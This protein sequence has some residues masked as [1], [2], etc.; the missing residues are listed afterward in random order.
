MLMAAM[1]SDVNDS[2]L[3]VSISFDVSLVSNVSLI[4]KDAIKFVIATMAVMKKH[5]V[6]LAS[7]MIPFLVV[8]VQSVPGHAMGLLSVMMD[9]MNKI[10]L[11]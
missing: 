2:H 11:L 10:A 6:T 1:S 3:A 7:V 4:V 9:L 5:V 8:M